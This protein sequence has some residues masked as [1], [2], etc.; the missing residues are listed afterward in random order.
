MSRLKLKSLLV[1]RLRSKTTP[2]LSNSV[3][4]APVVKLADTR[5]SEARA[6]RRI[7]STRIG[8]TLNIPWWRNGRRSGPKTRGASARPCSTH[9][10]GTIFFRSEQPILSEWI[11]G[12]EA[13]CTRLLNWSVPQGHRVFKSH[14][15]RH[16]SHRR[17]FAGASAFEE[18][19]D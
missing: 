17:S 14:R 8:G 15:I 12:R 3:F 6:A 18:V 19:R 9:G 10:H 16:F 2:S 5:V 4:N 11:R 1:M 13:Y 7:R